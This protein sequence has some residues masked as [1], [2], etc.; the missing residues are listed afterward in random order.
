MDYIV[1]DSSI[2][3]D[4]E[5]SSLLYKEDTAVRIGV[6]REEVFSDKSPETLYVVEV[7]DGGVTVPV[8][9]SRTSRY[10]G[11]YNYEEYTHRTFSPGNSPGS[12]GT[13]SVKQG[14]HVV[15]AYIK[16]NGREGVILGC[17]NHSGR[18]EVIN[19]AK[20]KKKNTTIEFIN[21]GGPT[22]VQYAAE[23]NGLETLINA[24]GEYRL[25]FRGQPTNIAKL[26]NATK[27]E[28]I[29]KAEYD[30]A[31]GSSYYEFDKTG[32]FLL[33][34]NSKEKNQ[35]IKLDKTNGK[36]II[37]SGLTTLTI[38]K[39]AESYTIVNKKTTINSTDDV[40]INT[41]STNIKSTDVINAE[42]KNIN[43]KG[44]WFQK[45]N[46]Q[47]EG[48]IKQTGNTAIDGNFKTSGLTLLA[49]GANPLIYD[50]ILTYGM[51]NL[52]A[53]VFSSHI[54]LKTVK[55]KAT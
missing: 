20:R 44:E 14:D 17:L 45:G 21:R 8:T 23:F 37:T 41:K 52:S 11:I 22:S 27:G 4:N 24:D 9:C 1:K 18:D 16:G 33:T 46:M 3:R 15:V 12:E 53:P 43:T 19:F 28:E 36:I 50:I 5:S 54:F 47:I 31:I 55:T 13:M 25:T 40:S 35:S 7:W 26:S 6:V 49:G 29:A 10:G 48:N 30:T 39:N 34:D 42:S 2:W 32:S 38:D 51:G